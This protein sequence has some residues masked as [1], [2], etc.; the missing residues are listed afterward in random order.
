MA[1]PLVAPHKLWTRDESAVLETTG[2]VD[3]ER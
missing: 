1:S 3:P 2:L